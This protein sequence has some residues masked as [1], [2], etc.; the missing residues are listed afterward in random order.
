MILNLDISDLDKH[1]YK[2]QEPR[3]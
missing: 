3:N 2:I 1:K